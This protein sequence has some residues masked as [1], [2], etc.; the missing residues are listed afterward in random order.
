MLG[1]AETLRVTRK[2][3]MVR[4][5]SGFA[6]PAPSSRE[7]AQRPR[8]Y[9][10]AALM[11]AVVFAL[12]VTVLGTFSLHTAASGTP[13][14]IET[15]A[16]GN[17]GD[18]GPATDAIVNF[19][20]GVALDFGG[21]LYIADSSNCRVRE[22]NGG[23]IT[24][25]AG[26]PTC[27]YGGDGGPATSAA[28]SGPHG[29]AL[30]AGGSLYIADLYNCRVREVSGGTIVTVA[31]SGSCGYSGDG[32]PATSAELDHP[33][34]VAV[35]AGGDLYIADTDNCRVRKVSGGTISTVAGTGS[36]AYSGDGG[37]A[38][39]AELNDPQGL[40][41]D[42]SGDLYIADR[43]N[44]RVRRVSAGTITTIAGTASCGYSGDGGPAA[45]AA[46]RAPYGLAVDAGG[47]LYIADRSNCAV[48]KVSG[49]T[50]T[51]VAGGSCIVATGDGG[52]ATSAMVSPS[53][54]V[55][56][57]NGDLYVTENAR[58]RVREVSGGIIT[59]V[60]GTGSCTYAGDGGPA[61]SATLGNP[62]GLASE[63]TGGLYIVDYWNCRV[64]KV[65]GGI[66]TTVVGAG[67]CA[68]SGD[69]GP[70]MSA[71]LDPKAVALDGSGNLYIADEWNC[72]VRKVSGGTI[73]TFAGQISCGSS[74]D[75][76]PPANATLG[77][78][79]AWRWT[80]AGTFTSRNPWAA[81]CEG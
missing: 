10:R 2:R 53:G 1:Y 12:A 46:L 75:G 21:N 80:P 13:G 41:V 14:T 22:V 65:N 63:G 37:A 42:G 30:S 33:D 17:V 9:R 55:V 40:A 71:G 48:R 8:A 16:G 61:T 67:S 81:A 7:V 73:T 28:L 25:F 74:G 72:R 36:C 4:R 47:D 15:F 31:G 76:G 66:M 57:A 34:G 52:P 78:P 39:A 69:G 35:D 59:T 24:T 51:T 27:G 45:S 26:I 62:L 58:C 70:A 20:E 50:I 54:V 5:S 68:W 44:C 79:M 56:D 60:A 6:R 29:L 43:S 77:F 23:M 3:C 49:G 11:V 38:T 64:R 19:P 32:G 18:G